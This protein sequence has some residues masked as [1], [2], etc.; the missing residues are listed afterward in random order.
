MTGRGRPLRFVAI[1]AAG[2]A[3]TRVL[4]LWPDGTTLPQA[5][6]AA[7]PI[8]SAE[9]AAPPRPMPQPVLP[10]PTRPTTIKIAPARLS[11]VTAMPPTAN[12]QRDGFPMLGLLVFGQEEVVG[13]PPGAL[14]RIPAPPAFLPE[15]ARPPRWSGSG[16]FMIRS[17]ATAGGPMLGGDQ[18]GIRVAY[19]FGRDRRFALYARASAPG[20]GPGR[21]GAIGV[22]WR[23]V[24]APVR[25]VA[26][27]RIGLDDTPGGTAV[28]L[29]GGIDNAALPFD[30]RLEAYGQAGIV[31]RRRID[32]FA[33]GALRITRQV[34]SIGRT[35]I[36][37]GGGAW[38]AA[39][40]DVARL[41]IGPTA[42]AT[43]PLGTRA[44]R[45]AIDWRERVEG[46]ARPGSGPALTLGADF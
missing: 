13:A 4:L 21:E 36:D 46:N 14:P 45:V 34:A 41:D 19:S 6:E 38:G 26:E 18:A 28:G 9:A 25:L 27:R 8:H 30:F 1:I 24:D 22:E 5:I 42:V 12:P 31:A 32:P 3:G 11:F 10:Q 43:V 39:Q 7:F 2:W 16:W 15:R 40:R 35:R 37:L 44:V 17:G 23:P 20:N 29:V 33:D